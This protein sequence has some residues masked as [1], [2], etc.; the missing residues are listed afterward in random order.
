MPE[1]IYMVTDLGASFGTT[2]LVRG[3]EKAKGN[4]ESYLHSRF[5][6]EVKDGF[7][8]FDDPHRPSVVVLVNPHEFFSRV[9]LE[10]IGRD[11]PLDDVRWIGQLLSQLSD[12]QIRDAFRA[13]GYTPEEV[14]AFA[15]EV[16]SRIGELKNL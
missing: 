5:I 9:N 11:I 16:Q 10:W 7:V 13:A 2:H 8:N 3:H 15:G 6:R 1:Q 14:A 12:Q 4:L